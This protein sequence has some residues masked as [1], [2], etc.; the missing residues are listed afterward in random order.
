[1]YKKLNYLASR[2]VNDII[3]Q[4]PTNQRKKITFKI[5]LH[6]DRLTTLP[7]N[8]PTYSRGPPVPPPPIYSFQ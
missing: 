5:I 2:C 7:Q 4:K 1:M 8:T 6:A 3:G